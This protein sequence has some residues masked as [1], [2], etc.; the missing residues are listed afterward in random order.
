MN[1]FVRPALSVNLPPIVTSAAARDTSSAL[2]MRMTISKVNFWYR[3]KQVLFDDNMGIATNKVTSLTCPSGC[4][5]STL[6]R[7]LNRIHDTDRAALLEGHMLL[8]AQ[9]IL[10]QDVTPH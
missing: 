5:N 3:S 2:T 6:P 10:R 7:T 1:A 4:G 8:D 9:N